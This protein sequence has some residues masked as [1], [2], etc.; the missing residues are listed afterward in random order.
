[1]LE[2]RYGI[3]FHCMDSDIFTVFHSAFYL[4]TGT[5]TNIC[6]KDKKEKGLHNY[7]E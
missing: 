6:E 4:Y 7:G 3:G 2:W 1:M 5:A